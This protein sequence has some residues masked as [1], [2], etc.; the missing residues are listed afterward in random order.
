MRARLT[1]LFLIPLSLFLTPGWAAPPDR[2]HI[3]A[4]ADKT[5][6]KLQAYL[7]QGQQDI[8][9][10]RQELKKT[11]GE[12]D[13]SDSYCAAHPTSYLCFFRRDLPFM[14]RQLRLMIALSVHTDHS[15]HNPEG[16]L[17]IGNP[18]LSIPFGI[19]I[20]D[21]F[22]PLTESEQGRAQKEL[23]LAW[24]G[25]P[26]AGKTGIV[27]DYIDIL[28]NKIP[29][30]E[31]NP[32]L[33]YQVKQRLR[34]FEKTRSL[35]TARERARAAVLIADP[36]WAAYK[37]KRWAGIQSDLRLGIWQMIERFRFLRYLDKSRLDPEIIDT[38]L[39][40]S[41]K[42]NLAVADRVKN[43][44]LDLVHDPDS[45][46]SG[47][48]ASARAHLAREKI[49]WLMSF[50]NFAEEALKENPQWSDSA[51]VLMTEINRKKGSQ[52]MLLTAA[53]MA[54]VVLIYPPA[55]LALG[56]AGQGV[57]LGGSAVAGATLFNSTLQDYTERYQFYLARITPSPEYGPLA[58]GQEL[59]SLQ[60][61]ILISPMALMLSLGLGRA[62]IFTRLK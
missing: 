13:P 3:L 9:Q 7:H 42:D 44:R 57:I 61:Q 37:A 18:R 15:P 35:P 38:A 36:T 62:A 30:L 25:F 31:R 52:Q 17:S 12:A 22:E 51:R 24:D 54:P 41:L 21:R 39:A 5:A 33:Q 11:A 6:E 47:A 45:S 53:L 4:L 23:D 58:T 27:E 59:R 56:L 40:K 43:A 50:E 8:A 48:P 60:H 26:E 10:L 32:G 29:R 34:L 20:S 46:E 14:H 49:E 55:A 2:A 1:S 16:L 19:P 28:Q